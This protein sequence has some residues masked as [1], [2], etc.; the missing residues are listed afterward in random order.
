MQ[1]KVNSVRIKVGS[2]EVEL[3]D[4][5]CSVVGGSVCRDF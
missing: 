4:V 1:Q 2:E 5:G 3:K